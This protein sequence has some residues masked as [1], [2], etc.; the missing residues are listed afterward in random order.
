MGIEVIHD[1]P[2]AF[3]RREV[4]IHQQAHLL[5]K[6]L[7]G[8]LVGDVDVTPTAPRLDEQQ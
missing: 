2:D 1:Q 3:G 8:S 4:V 7:F 5:G 6:V